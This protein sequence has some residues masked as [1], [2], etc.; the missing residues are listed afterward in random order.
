MTLILSGGGAAPKRACEGLVEPSLGSLP[1]L[2][3]LV[4]SY[5]MLEVVA[6]VH[7]ILLFFSLLGMTKLLIISSLYRR[8]VYRDY[9]GIQ[10]ISS[11]IIQSWWEPPR[12][13]RLLSRYMHTFY[14]PVSYSI[15]T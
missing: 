1:G 14:L 2:L 6:A 15:L 9:A 8:D 3:I 10:I 5:A 7:A 11:I 4:F 13:L 12:C